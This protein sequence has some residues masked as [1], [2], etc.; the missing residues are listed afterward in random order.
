MRIFKNDWEC[1][2]FIMC[3]MSNTT[4]EFSKI[5][6]QITEEFSFSRKSYRK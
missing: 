2:I 3:Q 6:D 4:K 1:S 5:C